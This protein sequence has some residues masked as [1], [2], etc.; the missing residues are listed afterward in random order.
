[1]TTTGQYASLAKGCYLDHGDEKGQ[2]V[3]IDGV[4]YTIIDTISK[5]ASG[6]QGTAYQRLGGNEIAIAYRGTEAGKD[7]FRDDRA[8]FEMVRDRTNDQLADADGFT[9]RVMDKAAINASKNHI[10]PPTITVTGHSL[11]G[12]LAEIMAARYN[13]GGETSTPMALSTSPTVSP[14]AC[15]RMHR[16]SSTMSAPPTWSAR[17]VATMARSASMPL[18]RM[19]IGSGTGATSIDP[20]PCTPPTRC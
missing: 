5:T 17:R 4:Q 9:R 19:S 13:L 8:D 3:L 11:G 1:M 18:H 12:T 20:I 15:P 6:F 10:A 7:H 14:K 2:T 16:H